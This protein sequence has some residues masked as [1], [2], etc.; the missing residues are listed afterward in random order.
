M[1]DYGI[2]H[3]QI[4]F[5]I[6]ILLF[7][8]MLFLG[9]TIIEF[10][11]SYLLLHI[12]TRINISIISD[13][14]IKL[15]KLP[16][17]F[18][19]SRRTGDIMQ[20]I[21]D[22]KRIETFITQNV[23]NTLFSIVNLVVMIIVV[24][25]YNYKILMVFVAGSCLSIIWN[26]VFMERIKTNYYK[27]FN[28]LSRN[29]DDLY[30]IIK[31]IEEIKLNDFEIHRRWKW[32]ITQF[33]LFKL[34]SRLLHL[35]Q[36]QRIGS[37]FFIQLMNIFVTY[38][39]AREV[40]NGHIT[41][42]VMLTIAYLVGQMIS[43][44]EQLAIFFNAAQ[45]AKISLERLNEV[46][47]QLNE[48]DNTKLIPDENFFSG[49]NHMR[50]LSVVNSSGNLSISPALMPKAGI[51]FQQV[52]FR[53][54]GPGSPLVLKEINLYIPF[55]KV[56]AIVGSSG[57]GK[58]TL[59]KLLLKFYD[60]TSGSILIR[61]NDLQNISAKWWRRKCGIVMQEGFI[62]SDTIR[63]NISTGDEFETDDKI[64]RAIRIANIDEFINELPLGIETKIGDAGLGLSSGQKQRILIAR[65]VYKNPDLLL[66]DEAT[67][68]LDA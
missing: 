53:Y 14:L 41:L 44:I 5:I 18:F 22:H 65:A 27:L 56:T 49:D 47:N 29:R 8:L 4:N 68:S 66:F 16:L 23:L 1:V 62:F 50:G 35:R 45:Q 3:G 37:S 2:G 58:T 15:M 34:N 25:I 30:E 32:E 67:S 60:V 10:L 55:G 38:I 6:I 40:V 61:D 42:G 24:A 63:K 21:D 54:E 39:S 59:F 31:G 26:L 57:S 46:H 43:P 12:G 11:R 17:S 19:E 28:F 9:N 48:E 20:R 64:F 13:F 33:G 36:Y 52:S 7:Q 51:Q